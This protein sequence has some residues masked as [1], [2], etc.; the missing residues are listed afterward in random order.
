M[1]GQLLCRGAR[2]M[3]AVLLL[4]GLSA[5]PALSIDQDGASS[6]RGTSMPTVTQVSAQETAEAP[7]SPAQPQEN[8]LFHQ[9]PQL[10]WLVERLTPRRA[11]LGPKEKFVTLSGPTRG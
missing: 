11:E 3:L 7:A 2:P 4:V 6:D 10:Q 8:W 5:S 9:F 1:L